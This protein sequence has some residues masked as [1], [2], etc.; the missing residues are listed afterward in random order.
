MSERKGLD[1]IELKDRAQAALAR[2]LKSVAAKDRCSAIARLAESGPLGAWW[3]SLR[4]GR[5]PV[6]SQHR[7]TTRGSRRRSRSRSR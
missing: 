5:D 2:R 4:E 1:A 7:A 3:K 6:S